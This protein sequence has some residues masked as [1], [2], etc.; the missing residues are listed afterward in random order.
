M[1]PSV[2]V[3][4]RKSRLTQDVMLTGLTGSVVDDAVLSR[5]ARERTS[6]TYSFY[7][8]KKTRIDSPSVLRRRECSTLILIDASFETAVVALDTDMLSQRAC[9]C[10]SVGFLHLMHKDEHTNHKLEERKKGKKR[11]VK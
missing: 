9:V 4:S 2:I 7:L 11:K 5:W 1:N 3:D 8:R 10:L 6:F